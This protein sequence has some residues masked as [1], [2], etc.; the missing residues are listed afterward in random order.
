MMIGART[1]MWA[2]PPYDAE[3]EYLSSTANAS[4]GAAA[5]PPV[6]I[7]TGVALSA[8]IK[9]GVVAAFGSTAYQLMGCYGG[10]NGRFDI[11]ISN[12]G[13]F[14]TS[15]GATTTR[16][17][18][19][20]SVHEFVLDV[21][22]AMVYIDGA[23][24]PVGAFSVA[25]DG[26]V[27]LFSR[28]RGDRTPPLDFTMSYSKVNIKIYSCKIWDNGVLVRDFIPVR[29]GSGNAAVGYMYDRVTGQLFGNAG[30]GAF[31]IGPDANGEG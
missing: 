3:V 16:T 22:S 21:P 6:Y 1:A 15:I 18:A 12:S 25:I 10:S 4:A 9:M 17:A 7:D 28:G 14:V 27:V 23:G 31:V 8:N 13:L 20:T 24:V 26:N 11:G 5:V 2:G 29:V 19:D 30:T